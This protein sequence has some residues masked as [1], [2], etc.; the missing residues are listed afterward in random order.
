[1]LLY[2][3]YRLAN[4]RG[5]ELPQLVIIGSRGWLS[6][7]LQYLIEHDPEMADKIIILDGINDAGLAW[8]YEHCEFTIYPSMYEGWGLP[9]AE[10]LANGKF[11]IAS[12]NSSVPEIAG[13]LIDYF[14]PYDSQQCFEMIARYAADPSVVRKKEQKIVQVYTVTTWNDSYEQIRNAL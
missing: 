14:S 3:A 12:S 10:S 9:V 5:V 7:D 6:G 13:S 4:E 2:Y 11:C 1:M 8:I